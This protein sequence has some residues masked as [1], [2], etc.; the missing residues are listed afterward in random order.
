[1]ALRAD[2]VDLG[3]DRGLVERSQTGDDGAFEDLY[4][5][6]YAR[7]Y[8]FC[9]QR[10][11]DPHE[12]EELTQEAFV[13][14]YGALGRLAGERRFYP[15]LSVIASRLCVD[16]FRRRARS[17]PKA[18]ID[19]GGDGAVGDEQALHDLDVELLTR[20]L[21]RVT[22]RH[23][24]VL[25]LREHEGWS[26]QHIAQHFGV[27]LGSVEAL[28][29]RARK[30]LRREFDALAGAEGRTRGRTGGRLVA[31]P[32]PAWAARRLHALRSRMTGWETAWAP[33]VGNAVAV[34]VVVVGSAMGT[35]AG[36]PV[37]VRATPAAAVR[38]VPQAPVPAPDHSTATPA[39]TPAPGAV[40]AP[41]VDGGTTGGG[42]TPL[43]AGGRL[44]HGE[45]GRQ[46]AEDQPVGG[47]AGGVTVG[48][49]PEAALS[50]TVDR[51]ET[52]VE[53]VS[54]K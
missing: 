21:A 2:D 27:S 25:A 6:Y 42:S 35:G 18:V 9:L 30:A 5:R 44:V 14:A 23:R 43:V 17:E 39:A 26:Y 53:Q 7:L 34:A 29:H 38:P 31:L 15:W 51:A 13:R 10:V 20:A 16:A 32:V 24:E 47:S 11:R 54:S 8:R 49:D 37:V 1:M 50:E 22:P 52:Y 28:L 3:R 4:R 45:E 33:V 12:A 40:V 48:A 41:V 19:L 36:T 46:R